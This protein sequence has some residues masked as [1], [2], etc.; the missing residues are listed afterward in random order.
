M[1]F[2]VTEME[3]MMEAPRAPL[4]AVMASACA[5]TLE[6]PQGHL[7]CSGDG[8]MGRMSG[9]ALPLEWYPAAC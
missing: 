7:Q 2:G 3:V 1:G 5:A 6:Q 9:G 4:T 8:R